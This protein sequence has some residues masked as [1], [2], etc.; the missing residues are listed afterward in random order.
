MPSIN[1]CQLMIPPKAVHL[2][3]CRFYAPESYQFMFLVV[4]VQGRGCMI[5]SPANHLVSLSLSFLRWPRGLWYYWA[6]LSI[7]VVSAYRF[8]LPTPEKEKTGLPCL[9]GTDLM[10]C[11][12]SCILLT[13]FFA[14]RA[15]FPLCPEQGSS[16][17]FIS[18]TFKKNN[19]RMNVYLMLSA[20]TW[21]RAQDNKNTRPS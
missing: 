12:A 18:C 2:F 7:I 13:V 17:V 6:E 14:E 21:Y 11:A 3:F 1:R 20:I 10:P 9:L 16:W 5:Q 8:K 4:V 19:M 15:V